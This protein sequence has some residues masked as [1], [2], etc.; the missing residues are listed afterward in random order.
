MLKFC[1]ICFTGLLLL[2]PCCFADAKPN[3]T[4]NPQPSTN[5]WL[6][7][8]GIGAGD[9]YDGTKGSRYSL[10]TTEI[11]SLEQKS[12]Q[13]SLYFLFSAAYL[14]HIAS[15]WFSGLSLGPVVYYQPGQFKGE[16]YQF[17]LPNLN[18]FKYTYRVKPI[19]VYLE[20]NLF[21]APLFHQHVKPFILIGGGT[22]FARLN[23]EEHTTPS[24]PP[25]GTLSSRSTWDKH[26]AYEYGAGLLAHFNKHWFAT[27]RYVHQQVGHVGVRGQSL[28]HAINV[29]LN[30]N[31]GYITV[32]YGFY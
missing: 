26:S 22:S 8:A 16:V 10:S 17:E 19:N 29:N 25:T 2:S 28:Q 7:M 6:V 1:L 13:H 15:P 4:K 14:F 31:S 18:N 5:H 11:D 23:Y 20:A 32:G 27:L 21:F 9:Y 3:A 30:N 12:Q 24:S